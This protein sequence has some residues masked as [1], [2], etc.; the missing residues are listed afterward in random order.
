M[1][2]THAHLDALDDD[3]ADVVARAADAG[4][5]R[6]LTVGTREAVALA[7][8]F[9]RVYAIVGVHPHDAAGAD[10]DEVRRLHAHPKAVAVGETGLD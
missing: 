8:R 4:V 5:T 2:D 9:E 3:P 6:I 10:L 1:I 7:E